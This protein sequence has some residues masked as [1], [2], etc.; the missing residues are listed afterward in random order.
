VIDRPDILH[1]FTGFMCLANLAV[2]AV[3]RTSGVYAVV[4][5]TSAEPSFLSNSP[6][7]WSKGDPTLPVAEL[8]Q[9][10]IPGE[11]VMY[12]GKAVNLRR[13]LSEYRRNGAGW[14]AR[15]WGGR[16]IWQLADHDSLL[17]AWRECSEPKSV[18][19]EMLADFRATHSGSLPYANRVG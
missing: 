8:E 13:R 12:I 1:N 18:E 7:G 5:P 17:V 19:R 11:R 10:W 9:N 15:H 14:R 16:M 4:R 6:A 3:P 2:S